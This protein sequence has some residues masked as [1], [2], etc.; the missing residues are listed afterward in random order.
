MSAHKDIE[1][2]PVSL[3]RFTRFQK[4][5]LKPLPRWSTSQR[6]ISRLPLNKLRISLTPRKRRMVLNLSKAQSLTY[7]K[8]RKIIKRPRRRQ[9]L[10]NPTKRPKK[11]LKKVRIAKKSK[12]NIK[13]K[14]IKP[15]LKDRKNLWLHSSGSIK[16]ILTK[17]RLNILISATLRVCQSFLRFGGN[18]AMRSVSL[19]RANTVKIWIHTIKSLITS[20]L[21]TLKNDPRKGKT[22]KSSDSSW[23]DE[24]IIV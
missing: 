18:L 14:K 4:Y 21:V 20:S 10:K 23:Y 13:K 8:T 12:R 19:M 17:S 5:W 11:N 15:T 2:V 6:I 7:K 3:Y 24:S 16:R 9:R 1:A 22:Q